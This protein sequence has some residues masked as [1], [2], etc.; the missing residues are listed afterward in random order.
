[1]P[2][3]GNPLK[4]LLESNLWISGESALKSP[5]G[6][7]IAFSSLS[8]DEYELAT[9][10][11]LSLK[12]GKPHEIFRLKNPEGFG[13]VAW[14]P[15]GSRLLFARRNFQENKVEVWQIPAEG[16]QPQSLGLSTTDM[17]SSISIHPD[18]N[19]IAFGSGQSKAEIWVME[20]FLPE[21][22][23]QKK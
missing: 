8:G 2:K 17:T 15:D 21:A 23:T 13:A 7:Q 5:D 19:R 18:G 3:G 6:E 14:S 4:R 22:K 20:N 1:M 12:E 9:L 11:V 10:Y 16:G